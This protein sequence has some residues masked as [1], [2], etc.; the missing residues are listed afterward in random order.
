MIEL[1][2]K[3]KIG[4]RSPINFLFTADLFPTINDWWTFH[5]NEE[6]KRCEWNIHWPW[7]EDRLLFNDNVV[8]E[9]TKE[10]QIQF[11]R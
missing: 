8:Q 2:E 10:E 6:K 3:K 9:T 4:I 11:V 7:N 1:E 5:S